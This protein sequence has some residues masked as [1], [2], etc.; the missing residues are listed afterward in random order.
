LTECHLRP[1]SLHA[2]IYDI[3]IVAGFL[4]LS[5]EF[6]TSYLIKS[7]GE[8]KSAGF[9]FVGIAAATIWELFFWGV[10]LVH[11]KRQTCAAC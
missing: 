9:N 6:Y 4:Y 5:T 2:W 10:I 8:P 1:K 7:D 11:I 3:V